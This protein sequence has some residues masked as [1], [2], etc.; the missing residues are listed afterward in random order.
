VSPIFAI[1]IALDISELLLRRGISFRRLCVIRREVQED[2]GYHAGL[3]VDWLHVT[4]L[5]STFS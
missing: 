5:D 1:E 4:R 2:V 3:E